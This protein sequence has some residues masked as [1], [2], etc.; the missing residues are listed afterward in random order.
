[1]K[2]LELRESLRN[3]S[4]ELR[5]Y[6]TCPRSTDYETM[7][8]GSEYLSWLQSAL[9]FTLVHT[10]QFSSPEKVEVVGQATVPA[11]WRLGE[12]CLFTS[13]SP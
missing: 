8:A 4:K 9:D 7:K 10:S 3:L 13:F 5:V 11:L 12:L 1:M 6:V 2:K